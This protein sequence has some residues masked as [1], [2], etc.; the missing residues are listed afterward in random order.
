MIAYSI[1]TSLLMF[2]PGAIFVFLFGACVGSFLNVVIYRLP[3]GLTL[4]TPSS[5]CPVCGVQLKF[6]RENLPILGWFIVR[7]RC[8]T[9]HVKISPV[10]P[11]IEFIVGL[12]F[13]GLYVIYFMVDSSTA[14]WGEIGG[15]W[16]SYNQFY[17]AWPA[18][19]AIAFLISGLIA[20]T[21]IDARTYTIPIQIPLFITAVGL[22]AAFIQPLT[23]RR[24]SNFEQWPLPGVDWFWFAIAMGGCFGVAVAWCL[25]RL[26]ITKY[27]FRD[28]HEYVEEGDTLGDYP[29]ARR[30]MGVETLYLCPVIIGLAIGLVVG[31]SLNPGLVPPVILQSIGGS[32][33]GYLVGGGVVWALRIFGTLAFG[34]EAIGLGD[35]HLL[36]AVGAVLG[37]FDP[38]LIFFIAPFSGIAW[39]AVSMGIAGVFKRPR[40]E[41]PYGP[42]LAVATLVVII[43]RGPIERVW[44]VMFP[45]IAYP[46]AE[47]V[48]SPEMVGQGRVE[49]EGTGFQSNDLTRGV[50][51]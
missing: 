39:A 38:I 42:H 5:R 21:V 14:F 28:Y 33:L 20:M 50:R 18:F 47:L 37:W 10:Y 11:L 32:V 19:L 25:L 40:R 16:W 3:L 44:M 46:K 6:F 49:F 4:T 43:C 36:A 35:V 15:P 13:L 2:L 31:L 1:G 8:R 17:R 41:L 24:F 48:H 51:F 30:E 9:C 23:S 27:S 22:V 29:F 34:R 26:G 45:T 12:L 7:G